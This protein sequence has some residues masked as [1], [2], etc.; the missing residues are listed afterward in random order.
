[1]DETIVFHSLSEEHLEKIVDIQLRHLRA[2]LAERH[3]GLELTAEAARHLVRVGY[4]PDYGARPLKRAIQKEVETALARLIL[5][6][7]VRDG[8]DVVG[9]VDREPR[10][11]GFSAAQRGEIVSEIIK[12]LPVLPLKNSVLFPH[13]L[14]PLSVG[15]PASLAAVEAALATEERE[16]V[17]VAQRDASVEAPALGDLYA[18]GT[19][20]VIKS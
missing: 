14:M 9:D 17:I 7:E 11:A 5:N 20:A 6:G 1:M 12:L 15:R 19:K 2:R 18:I 16:I 4:E 10:G 3:I 8:E 13:L